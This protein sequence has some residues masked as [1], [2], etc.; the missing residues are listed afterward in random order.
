M[1]KTATILFASTLVLG[2]SACAAT[3]QLS[4]AETCE[5]VQV[6]LANPANSIGKTGMTQLANQLRPIHEAASDELK[7]ALETIIEYTDAQAM[8]EPDADRLADMQSSYQDASAA[9][10]ASCGSGS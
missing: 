1:K 9:F 7:P 6:V 8:E 5:R 3:T 4:T 2:A 10:N